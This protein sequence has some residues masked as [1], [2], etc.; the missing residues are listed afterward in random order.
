M[1]LSKKRL[2]MSQLEDTAAINVVYGREQRHCSMYQNGVPTPIEPSNP[3][4]VANVSSVSFTPIW[5]PGFI[6]EPYRS[7]DGKSS[8]FCGPF[9]GLFREFI[10]HTGVTR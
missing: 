4:T 2:R 9:H 10:E 5:V 6:D 3:A 7:K 1:L 8:V